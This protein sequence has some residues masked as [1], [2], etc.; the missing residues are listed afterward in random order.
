[1]P[2]T[3]GAEEAESIFPSPQLLANSVSERH[4]AAEGRRNPRIAARSD[5][6]RDRGDHEHQRAMTAAG[7]PGLLECNGSGA[8]SAGLPRY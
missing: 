1:M 4:S 3:A 6:S 7:R 2:G 5:P 8:N